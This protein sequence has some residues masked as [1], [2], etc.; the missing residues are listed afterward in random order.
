MKGVLGLQSIDIEGA[1]CDLKLRD[2]LA[3]WICHYGELF[4]ASE[5]VQEKNWETDVLFSPTNEVG[6]MINELDVYWNG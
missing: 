6:Y 1:I 3:K 4:G 2:D 5:I